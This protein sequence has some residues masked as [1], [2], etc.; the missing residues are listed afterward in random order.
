MDLSGLFIPTNSTKQY[1]N[2]DELMDIIRKV[3]SG[4]IVGTNLRLL[5]EKKC[6][7]FFTQTA[8]VMIR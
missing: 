3:L 4:K 1:S 5:N 8:E 7:A 6:Q 2:Y